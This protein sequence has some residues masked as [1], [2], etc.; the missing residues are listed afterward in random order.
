MADPKRQVQTRPINIAATAVPQRMLKADP[1]RKTLGIS[2][3][4]NNT[5]QLGRDSS[6]LNSG[7][8][9]IQKGTAFHVVSEENFP[10]LITGEIWVAAS[11]NTTV[12]GFEQVYLN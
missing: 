7:M 2:S 8:L 3:D 9:Q 5:I 4:A 6:M 12:V 11:A 10:D 1:L